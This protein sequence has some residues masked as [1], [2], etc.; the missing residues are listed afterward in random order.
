MIT[1][2]FAN[3]IQVSSECANRGR[4]RHLVIIEHYDQTRLEMAGL[5]HRFHGHA[6][7]ERRIA[8]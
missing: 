4:D 8:D 3:A 6:A 2:R 7:G 1:M 5:V